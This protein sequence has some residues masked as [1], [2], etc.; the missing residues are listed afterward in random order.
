M[1]DKKISSVLGV[2]VC[3]SGIGALALGCSGEGDPEIVQVEEQCPPAC[4][5]VLIS[6]D[7]LRAD[8]LGTYGYERDTSP[9]IDRFAT[10]SVVFQNA[11]SQST[12]KVHD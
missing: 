7:T 11:V 3:L 8:H 12:W 1:L 10:K 9:S 4:N 2:L 5:V 6:I